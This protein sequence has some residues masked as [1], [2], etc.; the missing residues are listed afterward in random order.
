MHTAALTTTALLALA[1]D[2]EELVRVLVPLVS[3]ALG[4]LVP[5]AICAYLWLQRPPKRRR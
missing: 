4:A 3:I 1:G 5:M 2:D